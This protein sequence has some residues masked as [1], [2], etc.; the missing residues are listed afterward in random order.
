MRYNGVAV[1]NGIVY[2]LNDAIGALQAFDASSGTQLMSHSFSDDTGTQM[3]DMGNSSGVSIARHM[4]FATA[5]A[6]GGSTLFA[7][8]LG[9]TGDPNPGG[10]DG[11]GDDGGG[12]D[13]GGSGGGS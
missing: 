13:G 1:A 5:Q 11:G 7:L 9:A 6:D 3:N 4:V 2:S 12:D 8:K 10:D